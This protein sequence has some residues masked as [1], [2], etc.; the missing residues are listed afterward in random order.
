MGSG[1]HN[2]STASSFLFLWR[3][4]HGRARGRGRKNCPSPEHCQHRDG[5]LDR[6]RDRWELVVGKGRGSEAGGGALNGGLLFWRRLASKGGL[7]LL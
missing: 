7:D 3:A 5:G 6:P 1:A 2:E 4:Y